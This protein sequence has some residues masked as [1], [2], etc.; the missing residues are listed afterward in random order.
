VIV[1]RRL[2]AALNDLAILAPEWLKAPSPP[3]WCPGYGW[4]VEND[5]LPKTDVAREQWVRVSAADG[6]Q[7]LPDLG[8]AGRRPARGDAD[9]PIR[10]AGGLIGIRPQ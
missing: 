1:A 6:D 8:L 9:V 4:R 7:R 10:A 5:H 2:R 3:E